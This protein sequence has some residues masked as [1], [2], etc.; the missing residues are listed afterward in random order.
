MVKT[1][2][3]E[4]LKLEKT[5]WSFGIYE[6]NT[7]IRSPDLNLAAGFAK[8][9]PDTKFSFGLWYNEVTTV[10]DGEFEFIS[11]SPPNFDKVDKQI[12]KKGDV[13]F[14]PKGSQ[15]TFKGLPG[16][17]CILFYVTAPSSTK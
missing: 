7:F 14:I 10:L 5:N 13:F 9:N 2:R 4:D 3:F 6:K 12:F 1:W 17:T 16:K 15:C 8:I 11:S